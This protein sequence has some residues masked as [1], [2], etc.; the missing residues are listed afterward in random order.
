ME[1]KMSDIGMLWV[2]VLCV[3]SLVQRRKLQG[4]VRFGETLDLFP[5]TAD[6]LR[7]AEATGPQQ[8]ALHMQQNIQP[9]PDDEGVLGPTMAESSIGPVGIAA[10]LVSTADSGRPAV[11]T[12]SM[13]AADHAPVAPRLCRADCQYQLRGVLV[14]SGSAR[15]GHYMSFVHPRPGDSAPGRGSGLQYVYQRLQTLERVAAADTSRPPDPALPVLRAIVELH[16]QH[17]LLASPDDSG[18]GDR[19]FDNSG[20]AVE[21]TGAVTSPSGWWTLNDEYVE[22]IAAVGPSG[23]AAI[24]TERWFGQTQAELSQPKAVRK[25]LSTTNAYMLFYDRVVPEPV[26]VADQLRSQTPVAHRAD[27]VSINDAGVC[28]ST[29]AVPGTSVAPG[30]LLIPEHVLLTLSSPAAARLHDSLVA[31]ASLSHSAVIESLVYQLMVDQAAQAGRSQSIQSPHSLAVS[32]SSAGTASNSIGDTEHVRVLTLELAGRVFLSSW[33]LHARRAVIPVGYAKEDPLRSPSGLLGQL[34]LSVAPPAP[35]VL[36]GSP[37]Q[38]PA[39]SCANLS[40]DA[41]LDLCER[42]LRILCYPGS[43]TAWLHGTIP[44]G[45]ATP[46]LMTPDVLFQAV[47]L[48]AAAFLHSNKNISKCFNQ[49]GK[50]REVAAAIPAQAL[51]AVCDAIVS[52]LVSLLGSLE[53]CLKDACSAGEASSQRAESSTNDLPT[54]SSFSVTSAMW[55]ALE[56]ECQL[57]EPVLVSRARAALSTPPENPFRLPVQPPVPIASESVAKPLSIPSRVARAV[58][59]LDLLFRSFVPVMA[60]LLEIPDPRAAV[61]GVGDYVVLPAASSRSSARALLVEVGIGS[62]AL[63]SVI[64]V[65]PVCTCVIAFFLRRSYVV[66]VAVFCCCPGVHEVPGAL[67]RARSDRSCAFDA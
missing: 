48:I 63:L 17:G 27:D 18:T 36:N 25:V 67:G 47:P 13:P 60:T 20:S 55:M 35:S 66:S 15:G 49:G 46:Q 57:P 64:C 5:Y 4:E 50:A 7:E 53:L 61:A 29:A 52:R 6:G 3:T 41:A 26:S 24:K 14:H 21:S 40:P 56:H 34:I 43:D 22:P 42:L 33:I 62:A 23:L 38:S 44:A 32:V 31:K 51:E 59:A 45:A 12:S 39:P 2:R 30:R 54:P 1:V 28:V 16:T 65:R 58:R 11:A 19:H 8:Q 10:G 9:L 37:S